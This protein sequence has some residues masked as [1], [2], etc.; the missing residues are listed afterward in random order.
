MIRI[1]VGRFEYSYDPTS[2][3]ISIDAP[4][5]HLFS[6]RPVTEQQP[7]I[8]QVFPKEETEPVASAPRDQDGES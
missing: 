3:K 2:A 4:H 1:G 5:T 8:R 6:Y 7:V